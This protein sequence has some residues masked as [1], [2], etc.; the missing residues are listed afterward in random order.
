M[1]GGGGGGGYRRR[2]EMSVSLGVHLKIFSGVGIF[3]E[4]L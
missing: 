4:F 3:N 1:G 2:E